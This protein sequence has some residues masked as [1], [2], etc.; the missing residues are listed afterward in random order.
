MQMLYTTKI[1]LFIFACTAG[2]VQQRTYMGNVNGA[3]SYDHNNAAHLSA[4]AKDIYR[5]ISLG[6][7][8]RD[9]LITDDQK[10]DHA[11]G[12]ICTKFG[13]RPEYINFVKYKNFVRQKNIFQIAGTYRTTLLHFPIAD[14]LIHGTAA[15]KEVIEEVIALSGDINATDED[16][17]TA[18]HFAAKKGYRECVDLLILSGADV[19]TRSL[20]GDTPLHAAVE[21]GH[22][23]CVKLLI[24]SGA[25]VNT[26][27]STGTTPLYAAVFRGYVQ[28]VKALASAHGVDINAPNSRGYTPLYTAVLLAKD[29]CVR[30]LVA[31]NADVSS[32]SS[33][34]GASPLHIAANRNNVKCIKEL[35]ASPHADV[36]ICNQAG[37]SFL[38]T[39]VNDKRLEI[40]K[41]AM[42]HGGDQIIN[43]DKRYNHESLMGLIG[44][45]VARA[46]PAKIAFKDLA[47]SGYFGYNKKAVVPLYIAA[48]NSDRPMINY[49]I[50]QGARIE[51]ALK[52]ARRLKDAHVIDVLE[53]L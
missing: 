44:R 24:L 30:P 48:K 40:V 27:S 53:T 2:C 6:I 8:F 51:I 23:Y 50:D 18:L 14:P 9:G 52:Q 16:G 29:K 35:L 7:A 3:P 10:A 28:C 38:Y 11:R 4:N 13:I 12:T 33:A 21:G 31:A 25:D 41:L 17:Y 26:K 37:A 5:T 22:A 42:R 45:H 1:V 43:D 20:N 36:T 46:H 34:L 49:L 15:L 32:V 39:A 19:N 47:Y